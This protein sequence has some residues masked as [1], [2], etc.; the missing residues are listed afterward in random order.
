MTVARLLATDIRSCPPESYAERHRDGA[1]R[2][3][4]RLRA[5]ARRGR[6]VMASLPCGCTPTQVTAPR[7][8][9]AGTTR[10]RRPARRPVPAANRERRYG[11]VVI[12]ASD[13]RLRFTGHLESEA[14]AVPNRPAMVGR[15]AL[16][17]SHPRR[18]RPEEPDQRLRPERA[19]VRRPGPDR[20]RPPRRRR[21]RLRRHRQRGR[22]ATCPARRP[23]VHPYR[24]GHALSQ[25]RDPSVR[26]DARPGR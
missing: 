26:L 17:P 15:R 13:G 12:S 6:G 2:H 21:R 10:R 25:Q 5:R 14:R 19:C 16:P 4:G 24:P 1:A 22:R 7:H 18:S 20:P 3:L 11:A 23:A 9:R 8:G